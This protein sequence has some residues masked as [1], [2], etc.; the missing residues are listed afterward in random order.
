MEPNNQP[1]GTPGQEGRGIA[2]ASMVCGIVGMFFGGFIL[3]PLAIIFAIV[4]KK[5]GFSGA[6][7]TAGLVLG[8]IAVVAAILVIAFCGSA[9]AMLEF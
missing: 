5:K 8:I 9:L 7:A 4:A 3:G 2:I 6:M 1:V